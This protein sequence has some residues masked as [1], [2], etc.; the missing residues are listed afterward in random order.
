MGLRILVPKPRVR[1]SLVRANKFVW[2]ALGVALWGTA[3]TLLGASGLAGVLR[4]EADIRELEEQVE[5]AA[6]RNREIERRIAAAKNDPA[7]IERL[8]REEFYLAKPGET[9]YLLP[10][11]SRSTDPS[12]DDEE[13]EADSSPRL[14]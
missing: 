2:A 12:P 10:P 8:A 11:S 14:P 3:Y 4:A 7:T 6:A 1:W 5:R 9:V 13:P